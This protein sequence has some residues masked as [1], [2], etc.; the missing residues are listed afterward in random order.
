LERAGAATRRK[1]HFDP[2]SL[3]PGGI[4]LGYQPRSGER[5]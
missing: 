3:L 1:A 4:A 5:A 2:Q